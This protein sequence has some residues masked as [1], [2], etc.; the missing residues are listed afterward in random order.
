LCV[1]VEEEEKSAASFKK[2]TPVVQGLAQ[3]I[4]DC[5]QKVTL[6]TEDGRL[7]TELLTS[8][9]VWWCLPYW[10]A[11]DKKISES[12]QLRKG[13]YFLEEPEQRFK[14]VLV[15]HA[16]LNLNLDLS[17]DGVAASNG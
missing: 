12:V 17:L 8:S 15:N 1:L 5:N 16:D 13:F 14:I 11:A 9:K 7:H 6:T 2:A 4:S 10:L 3:S